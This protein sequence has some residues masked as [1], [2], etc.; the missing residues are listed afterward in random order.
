[1][2]P[3]VSIVQRLHE[4][5]GALGDASVR[6]P[7]VVVVGGQSSGK[8]SVLENIV[9]R[10]FLP[11]GNGIVTRRPILMY[12]HNV[13]LVSGVDGGASLRTSDA[14]ASHPSTLSRVLTLPPPFQKAQRPVTATGA[15][16]SS[17]S[18]SRARAFAPLST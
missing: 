4:A 14:A 10:D 5:L 11:R 7:A 3:L 15:N 16:G 12:L 1:M 8:S 18:T 2:E 6:L 17:S 9:G 13:P